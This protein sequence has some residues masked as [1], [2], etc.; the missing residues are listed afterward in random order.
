MLLLTKVFCN[1]RELRAGWRLLLYLLLVAAVGFTLSLIVRFVFHGVGPHG[2]GFSAL[3]VLVGDSYLF[4]A[5]L[6]P[7]LIMGRI[8]RRTLGDYGLPARGAFGARFWEG[9]LWGFGLQ[10]VTILLISA[11]GAAHVNGL[12]VSAAAGLRYGILWGIAFIL[13]GLA[14]EF[15]FR[16]YT[17]FTLTTGM[18]FWPAAI[19]L[20]V[21]F[22]LTHLRNAGENWVGALGVFCASLVL[23]LPLRRTGALWFSVGLHAGWDWTETYFFGVPD[24]GQQASGYLLNTSFSG[25]H[26]LTG[27]TVGPEGSVVALAILALAFVLLHFRFPR[28]QYPRPGALEPPPRL[29]EPMPSVTPAA[30]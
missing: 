4:A 6:I 28:A 12:A 11:F 19:L 27:G 2:R 1:E 30:P 17:Q 23:V 24:S 21:L 14:E 8:E 16:G 29:P 7:A 25:S 13:V 22:A 3:S 10:V 15:S 9:I 18:H 5:V 26:W 20:S